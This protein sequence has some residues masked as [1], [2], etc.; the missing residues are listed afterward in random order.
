MNSIS[1]L[2]RENSPEG[3]RKVAEQFEAIFV[4]MMLKGMRELN[5]TLFKDNYLS[6]N[7]MQFHQENLDNQLSMHVAGSG[8][9]G[10]AEH[11]YRILKSR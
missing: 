7:E 2:G 4:N 9:I 8:G 10:L 3:L 6:S 1:Q 11:V 5:S